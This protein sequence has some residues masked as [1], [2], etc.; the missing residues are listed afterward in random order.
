MLFDDRNAVTQHFQLVMDRFN[1]ISLKFKAFVDDRKE[2]TLI[3]LS[4]S[5]IVSNHPYRKSSI[6]VLKYYSSINL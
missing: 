6:I 2:S 3:P 4:T 5:I 1:I